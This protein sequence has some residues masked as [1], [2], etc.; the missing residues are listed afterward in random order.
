MS[1][2]G[3]PVFRDSPPPAEAAGSPVFPEGT[4]GSTHGAGTAADTGEAID[5]GRGR[6]FPCESCG[7]DLEFHIG[8]QHLQCEY[9]GFAREISTL[10]AGGIREQDFA[11]VLQRQASRRRERWLAEDRDADATAGTRTAGQVEEV[12]E[13]RCESCGGTVVFLGSLTS[14]ECPWCASPVQREHVHRAGE[15]IPVDAVLPFLITRKEAEQRIEN[16]IRSLWLAPGDFRREGT[17]EKL[18]GIYLPFWTFDTLTTTEWAGQRG[19]RYT[20]RVRRNGKTRHVRKTRW[21]HVSGVFQRFFDDVLVLATGRLEHD[22]TEKLE[23]WPLGHCRPFTP[24]LLAG[25]FARTYEIELDAG[26]E[27]ARARI[28]EALSADIRRRIGGDRQRISQQ[29]TGCEAVTFKHVLL[30]VWMLAI[31]YEDRLYQV[32][33]N[34]GTGEVTGRR[35][36]SFWKICCVLLL[37]ATIAVAV[38]VLAR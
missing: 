18:N 5:E 27:L 32:V 33:V 34:A 7:A 25:H 1:E 2:A 16:W 14:T 24:E 6:I 31:R 37:A 35:P 28:D 29:E 4:S 19:D 13:I 12:N 11:T 38:A 8:M 21:S 23:P 3:E 10:A 17:G 9:C 20:E 15:R 22:L 30:P 26:F 36:W